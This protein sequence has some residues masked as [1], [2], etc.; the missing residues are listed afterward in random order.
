MTAA[1]EDLPDHPLLRIAPF[2]ELY[3]L[4]VTDFH[5]DI[6]RGAVP[7]ERHLTQPLG[8]VHGGVYATIGEALASMGTNRGVFGTGFVGLGL[9]NEVSFLRPV[10]RGHLHGTARR[11]HRDDDRWVWDIEITD[12]NGRVCSVGRV[13]VA[14]R[15]LPEG[16]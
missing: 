16:S 8:M 2:D 5:D 12:D 10:E 13:I 3:G 9:S 14:V 11:R 15:P 4:E 1:T 6:V 7:I